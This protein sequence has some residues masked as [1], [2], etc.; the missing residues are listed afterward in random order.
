MLAQTGPLHEPKSGPEDSEPARPG[1]TDVPITD[2]DAYPIAVFAQT[3]RAQHGRTFR[4]TGWYK[5]ARVAYLEPGSA[6]LARMLEQ[7]WQRTDRFGRMRPLQRDPEKWKESLGQ[8][9]AVVKLVRDEGPEGERGEL[10]VERLPD[11]GGEVEGGGS[12]NGNGIEQGKSVY[13]ML[14]EM[15]MKD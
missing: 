9:W 13:D 14:A 6:E 15:R 2:S 11:T 7:K 3:Q 12:G 5:L 8:R 10:R 4:H 1:Q